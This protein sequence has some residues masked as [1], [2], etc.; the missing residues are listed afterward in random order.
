MELYAQ[1]LW[2]ELDKG[3]DFRLEASKSVSGKEYIVERARKNI[4]Y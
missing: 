4:Y 1:K 3:I 2:P